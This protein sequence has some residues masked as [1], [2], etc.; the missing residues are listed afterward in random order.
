MA[1]SKHQEIFETIVKHLFSQ[2]ERST[3]LLPNRSEY[4]CA[5][6]GAN[7]HK[8]AV[9][10]VIPDDLYDPEMEGLCVDVIISDHKELKF[11]KPH[12]AVL[13]ELQLVHD[14]DKSWKTSETLRQRIREVVGLLEKNHKIKLNCDF[15]EHLYIKG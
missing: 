14:F 2:G 4:S 5:Y 15:I 8:C 7:G 10:I 13:S 6:R 3:V 12:L 11:L 9:G 1:V